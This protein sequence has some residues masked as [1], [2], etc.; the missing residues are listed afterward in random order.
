METRV[1]VSLEDMRK[2]VKRIVF[3]S[4]ELRSGR[5]L[6]SEKDE[7]YEKGFRN[8]T[9]VLSFEDYGFYVNVER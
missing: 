8:N 6:E 3:I 5:V 1:K 9:L 4:R 2:N 7:N